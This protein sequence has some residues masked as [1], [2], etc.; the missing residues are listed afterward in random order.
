MR[1]YPGTTMAMLLLAA[2]WIGAAS[3]AAS[4]AD[5]PDH[6]AQHAALAKPASPEGGKVSSGIPAIV[7]TDGEGKPTI[8][9]RGP[10]TGSAGA[11]VPRVVGNDDHGR[12]MIEY[13]G[14]G[15]GSLS[16]GVPVIIGSNGDGDPQIAYLPA[17]LREAGANPAGSAE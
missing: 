12:P 7:G 14:G 17:V 6:V 2:G 1:R 15:L 11:G 10:G 5:S 4:A 13:R 8:E 16:A 3:T 9:Y